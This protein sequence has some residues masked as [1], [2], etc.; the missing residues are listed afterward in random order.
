MRLGLKTQSRFPSKPLKRAPSRDVG[1]QGSASVGSLR[2]GERALLGGGR[3]WEWGA[4][5][6]PSHSGTQRRC[7]DKGQTPFSSTPR[8]LSPFFGPAAPPAPQPLP[9]TQGDRKEPRRSG[10]GPAARPC[11]ALGWGA[12]RPCR[13]RSGWGRG[14]LPV[15]PLP[16]R[17][18]APGPF[19]ESQAAGRTGSARPQSHRS[20]CPTRLGPITDYRLP[21]PRGELGASGSGVLLPPIGTFRCCPQLWRSAGLWG[22]RG[23]SQGPALHVA[24]SD[25]APCVLQKLGPPGHVLVPVPNTSRSVSLRP[26][27][28]S[29]LPCSVSGA[30]SYLSLAPCAAS[31]FCT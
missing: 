6:P 30:A 10:R 5:W 7:R 31:R 20:W 23:A 9:G 18:S 28:P 8:L 26:A 22:R 29:C 4:G 11:G 16:L 3:S 13:P 14:S 25:P 21:C 2:R 15:I 1:A 19:L 27:C 24:S 12:C 17:S